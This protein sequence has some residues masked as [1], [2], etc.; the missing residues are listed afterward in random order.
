MK[1]ST[2]INRHIN[3]PGRYN[4]NCIK[5][6]PLGF[7]CLLSLKYKNT[8]NVYLELS[9]KYKKHINRNKT[10]SLKEVILNQNFSKTIKIINYRDLNKIHYSD[11]GYTIQFKQIWNQYPIPPN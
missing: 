1:P 6:M 2:R 4:K 10:F 8:S 3:Q 7:S 11:L 9:H 5:L